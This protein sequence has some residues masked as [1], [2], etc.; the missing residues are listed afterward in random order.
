MKEYF[1]VTAALM[2]FTLGAIGFLTFVRNFD[3]QPSLILT[4]P[5]CAAPCW[6]GITP[7]Q[8]TTLQVYSALDRI[9]GVDKDR[10]FESYTAAGKPF[11]ITWYFKKLVEDGMGSVRIQNDR[12]TALSIMTVNSLKTADL[13]DKLGE[14]EEYWTEI[15]QRDNGEQFLDIML[16]APSKGYVA[17][18]V[19]DIK[20]GSDQVEIKAGTPVF[21]VT[22]FSPGMYQDIPE[23][24]I[25]IDKQSSGRATLQEWTGYGLILVHRES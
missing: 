23:T 25:L 6:Y 20:P 18:L 13:F 4:S 14:P 11:R 17:E 5:E 9:E 10:I 15:G 3:K 2:L 1:K 8:S 12:V 22:Y 21:R 16:L 24:S 19:V 7:G